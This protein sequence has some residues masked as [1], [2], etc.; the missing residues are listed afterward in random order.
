MAS[1]TTADLLSIDATV[2]VAKATAGWRWAP[3]QGQLRR[4]LLPALVLTVF[5]GAWQYITTSGQISRLILASPTAIIAAFGTS[6]GELLWNA[7]ITLTEALTGFVIG[8]TAGLLMAILFIHSDLAR[9]T[10]FPIAIGAEA[11]PIVAVV[12]VL[13]LWLGNGM[14]PKMFITSFLTF[15]P[16]LINALRGLRS[17]DAEV[18]ELLYTLSATARQRLF[19]VRLPASVPFLFNALK[20]SA[21]AC[22]VSAIVGEWLAAEAGLG[23]LIVLYATM[24]KVPEIWGTALLSTAMSLAVY[25]VVVVAEKLAMPWKRR[26]SISSN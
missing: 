6:G 1:E 5:L 26:S 3:A 25:G 2:D 9:R 10:I 7:G 24:Y 18:N 13:I 20:L 15:F 8:N 4:I 22:V 12:P 11:I 16:M 21:C 14:A 23:H 19:M 17:A